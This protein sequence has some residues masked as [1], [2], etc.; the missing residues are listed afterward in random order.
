MK[1]NYQNSIFR[2]NE[3]I[4]SNEQNFFLPFFFYFFSIQLTNR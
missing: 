4:I 2:K 3:N 1:K